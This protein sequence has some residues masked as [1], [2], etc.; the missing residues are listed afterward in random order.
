MSVEWIVVGVV[1]GLLIVL[2]VR[3]LSILARS[4]KELD[5]YLR[6]LYSGANNDPQIRPLLTGQGISPSAVEAMVRLKGQHFASL[7]SASRL[8]A[9]LGVYIGLCGTVVGLTITAWTWK[10]S[11]AGSTLTAADQPAVSADAEAAEGQ[12]PSAPEDPSQATGGFAVAFLSALA[13]VAAT[14]I[15]SWKLHGYDDRVDALE[16]ELTKRAL[17][18]LSMHDAASVLAQQMKPVLEELIQRGERTVAETK[19]VADEALTSMQQT[20]Q[21]A[22]RAFSATLADQSRVVED[23]RQGVEAAADR[24][25]ELLGRLSESVSKGLDD[26]G[27]SFGKAAAEAASL[28]A[29]EM[30]RSSLEVQTRA[31][32]RLEEALANANA[33]G[34][35]AAQA[36]GRAATDAARSAVAVQAEAVER[37]REALDRADAFSQVAANAVMQ[38]AKGAAERAARDASEAQAEA[39][40]QLRQALLDSIDRSDEL[41]RAVAELVQGA[42]GVS[43]TVE[44][45]RSVAESLD[46]CAAQF[47]DLARSTEAAADKLKDADLGFQSIPPRLRELADVMVDK[48][49]K[50]LEQQQS[51]VQAGHDALEGHRQELARLADEMRQF[52]GLA[53]SAIYDAPAHF[54]AGRHVLAGTEKF[55][56]LSR[57]IEELRQEVASRPGSA[58]SVEPRQQSLEPVLHRCDDLQAGLDRL[59]KLVFSLERSV[60]KRKPWWKI[61]TRKT[62]EA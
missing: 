16:R 41:R 29:A 36:A 59:E 9:Q 49:Q 5:E 13:G 12:S 18:R 10:P 32:G 3:A 31:I 17:E 37:L 34:E 33:F 24:S 30:A 6:G 44:V 28:A 43:Q 52:L 25:V 40:R 46:Q 11:A 23:I 4:G 7:V 39:L 15:L 1:W 62:E 14:V 47:S 58:P 8:V 48:S 54:E 45:A 20:H 27:R 2:A 51:A 42:A 60:R 50:M 55:E 26:V 57:R 22:V 56:E 53:L 38:A 61:W 19:R 35:E 21:E